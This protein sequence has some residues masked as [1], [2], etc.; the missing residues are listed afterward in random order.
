MEVTAPNLLIRLPR[1]TRP[2]AATRF[3]P[4]WSLRDGV[5]RKRK[6]ICAAVDGDSL[7]VYEVRKP[8]FSQTGHS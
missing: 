3:G 1:A 8:L 4:V 5:K 7:S 2:D 6:E